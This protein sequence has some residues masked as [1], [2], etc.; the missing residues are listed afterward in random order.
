MTFQKGN[1]F[2]KTWPPG[3]SGN[4]RGVGREVFTRKRAL[5]AILDTMEEVILEPGAI[6]LFRA[7]FRELW[8][9]DPIRVWREVLFP[10]CPRSTSLE[11]TKQIGGQLATLS[12]NRLKQIA[13]MADE[14]TAP[15]VQTI[16]LEDGDNRH[17]E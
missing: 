17:A 14:N 2:G 7:K 13:G 9:K 12:V 16:D 15:T 5:A 6:D 3:T 10:L 1:K 8:T 11:V 4:P